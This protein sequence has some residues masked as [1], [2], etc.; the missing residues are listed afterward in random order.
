MAHTWSQE[1][2]QKFESRVKA[3][4]AG[5][6]FAAIGLLRW[7]IRC[8]E[9]DLPLPEPLRLYLIDA[10]RQ[11]TL[12]DDAERPP[13]VLQAN[14]DKFELR[15]LA[16]HMEETHDARVA[17]NLK[18]GPGRGRSEAVAIAQSFLLGSSVRMEIENKGKSWQEA[19]AAVADRTG[20]ADRTISRAWR[21]YKKIAGLGDNK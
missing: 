4:R 15:K 3:A 9:Q 2:I 5:D 21:E 19:I 12:T 8:L 7:T 11:I 1:E 20:F 18:P 14:A 13:Q 6:V 17:L 16:K 10:F